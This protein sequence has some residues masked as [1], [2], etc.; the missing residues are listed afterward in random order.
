M[1]SNFDRRESHS[2]PFKERKSFGNHELKFVRFEPK[3]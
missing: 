2:K 3:I 1:P